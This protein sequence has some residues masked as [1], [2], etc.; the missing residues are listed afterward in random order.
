MLLYPFSLLQ[1]GPVA[2]GS[3]GSP[4]YAINNLYTL[5]DGIYLKAKARFLLETS[6]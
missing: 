1:A 6:R 4:F 5:K 3:V 2:P